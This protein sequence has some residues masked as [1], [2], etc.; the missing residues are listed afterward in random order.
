MDKN[1]KWNIDKI[2]FYC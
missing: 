2:Q 1:E